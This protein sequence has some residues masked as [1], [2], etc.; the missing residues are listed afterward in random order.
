MQPLVEKDASAQSERMIRLDILD[1]PECQIL[2]D[3]MG[4]AGKGS[5]YEAVTQRASFKPSRMRVRRT[6]AS[7]IDRE[8]VSP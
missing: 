8:A 7:H 1:K 2:K 4:E 6:A 5:P 3:R